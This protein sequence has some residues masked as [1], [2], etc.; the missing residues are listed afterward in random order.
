MAEEACALVACGGWGRRRE[1]I[2]PPGSTVPESSLLEP[3]HDP[4]RIRA[5]Y[6]HPEHARRGLGRLILRTCERAARSAREGFRR[7][8]AAGN[9]RRRAALP[10]RGVAR[11]RAHVAPLESW[12]GCARG[13]D[14]EAPRL[15]TRTLNARSG[16]G[17]RRHARPRRRAPGC[18]SPES[19]SSSGSAQ[20]NARPRRGRCSDRR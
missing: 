9:A 11:D 13:P 4:A 7:G 19:G 12:R 14:E 10:R 18:E 6:T 20:A 16:A 8:G 2:T 17:L 3:P 15:L 5:M 1:Y